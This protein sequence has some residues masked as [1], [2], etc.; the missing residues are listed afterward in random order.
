MNPDYELETAGSTDGAARYAGN[1]NEPVVEVE[2]S[3]AAEEQMSGAT[4]APAGIEDSLRKLRLR[5]YAMESA[6][7]PQAA[8]EEDSSGETSGDDEASDQTF[9]A[10]EDSPVI[11][12]DPFT[13]TSQ[14]G[15]E[16]SA[17][18]ESAETEEPSR[19]DPAESAKRRL[20]A[21]AGDATEETRRVLEQ[22]AAHAMG[23]TRRMLEQVALAAAEQTARALGQVAE[24]ASEQTGRMLE[25]LAAGAT[26]QAR[27]AIEK[28]AERSVTPPLGEAVT[29]LSGEVRRVGR[30]LFK[31]ARSAERNQDLFDSAIEELRRLTS[32][33]EQVPAQLHGAES[34][35]EVKAALC[36]EMLGV[37]DSLESSLAAAEE[38]LSRLRA[39]AEKSEED[40]EQVVAPTAVVAA[41]SHSFWRNRLRRLADRFAPPLETPSHPSIEESDGAEASS[42]RMLDQALDSM[43]QWLDGQQLLYERLLTVLENVGVHQIETEGEAFDPA[44]HRAVSAEVHNDVPAGAIVGEELRGY[45]LD[46]KILRYA[47]VI[48]ARNE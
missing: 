6:L 42:R 7:W 39:E 37:A 33:V 12:T 36:R 25:R 11:R 5:R 29:E 46:G 31:T 38:T 41:P 30:E 48:V 10:P 18:A 1:L 24:D 14:Q 23:Q 34:I 45:M 43:S 8:P 28:L 27:Q 3:A 44:R 17:A 9:V 19:D 32:R 40:K 20:A 2:E 21:L 26:A 22:A 47:E 15:A 16:T 4:P 35:R 13:I